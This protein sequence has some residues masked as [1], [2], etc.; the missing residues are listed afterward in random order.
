MRPHTHRYLLALNMQNVKTQISKRFE[1]AT[2]RG[3]CQEKCQRHFLAN[4][5][6]IRQ[7]KASLCLQKLKIFVKTQISKRFELATARGVCQDTN[8]KEI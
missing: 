2:A 4:I 3:V 1:L 7:D 5:T 8:L 6:N